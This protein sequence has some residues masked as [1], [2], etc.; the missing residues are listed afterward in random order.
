V[1]TS[2]EPGAPGV[3]GIHPDWSEKRKKVQIDWRMRGRSHRIGEQAWLDQSS[4][5]L[6]ERPL[7]G[8]GN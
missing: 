7:F 2:E 1:S 4:A 6:P 5:R 3:E 8:F